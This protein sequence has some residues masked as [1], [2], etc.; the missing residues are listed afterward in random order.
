MCHKSRKI[1]D[2]WHNIYIFHEKGSKLD[3]EWSMLDPEQKKQR[4]ETVFPHERKKAFD[5][6]KTLA[7]RKGDGLQ[8][9][10]CRNI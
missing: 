7:E 4:C 9:G 1:S 5:M 2:L 8:H 6:G 3:W 10:S